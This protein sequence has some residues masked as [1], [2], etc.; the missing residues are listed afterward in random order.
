MKLIFSLLMFTAAA[1]AHA[2]EIPPEV[3]MHFRQTAPV[4][5][6]RLELEIILRSKAMKT[7]SISGDISPFSECGDVHFNYAIM[8]DGVGMR[9]PKFSGFCYRGPDIVLKPGE[10]VK[11]RTHFE[12]PILKGID[13]KKALVEFSWFERNKSG[14]GAVGVLEIR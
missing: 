6:G 3:H 11:W 10:E 12:V 9:L 1:I 2:Q 13:T 7:V 8:I 5:D 4:K 14:R